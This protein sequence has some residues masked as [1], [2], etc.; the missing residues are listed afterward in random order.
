MLTEINAVKRI[1][2]DLPSSNFY[3]N[4]AKRA[5]DLGMVL[6]AAPVAV[7][8]IGLLA[9]VNIAAGG[10]PFYAQQ[11]VGKGGKLFQCWKLRTMVVNSDVLL[12]ELLE[13]CPHSHREWAA[14][15]K[16]NNDPRITRFGQF[17]R[18]SSLDELPQLWNILKGDMSIVGPRPVVIEELEKYG[19]S[20]Q[21]YLSMRPGLTGIWQTNGRNTVSYDARVAMDVTYQKRVSL[22]LDLRIIMSTVGVVVTRT[23]W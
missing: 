11:R 2:Y 13:K 3:Q 17:L 8:L 20:A 22:P 16:L 9:V 15:N 4:Y 12:K 19:D 18:K 5:L 6:I 23:G 14:S 21:H 1:H 10:S 7:V